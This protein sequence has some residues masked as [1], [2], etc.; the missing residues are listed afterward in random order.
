MDYCLKLTLYAYFWLPLRM[1]IRVQKSG[2][3]ASDII[4]EYKIRHSKYQEKGKFLFI[5]QHIRHPFMIL[6]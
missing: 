5:F 6:L 3:N 1:K 2:S 4:N